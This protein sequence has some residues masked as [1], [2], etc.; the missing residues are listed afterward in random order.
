MRNRNQ[1]INALLRLNDDTFVMVEESKKFFETEQAQ[2]SIEKD[3]EFRKILLSQIKIENEVLIKRLLTKGYFEKAERVYLDHK[4]LI[5]LLTNTE[6]PVKTFL[7]VLSEHL[8]DEAESVI[9]A[10]E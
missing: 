9:P 4:V 2:F 3:L 8:L 1:L 5:D 10:L 6:K 7:N